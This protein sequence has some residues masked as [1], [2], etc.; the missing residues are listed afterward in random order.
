MYLG[1]YEHYPAVSEALD[2][3]R[4]FP[5]AKPLG[6]V[7]RRGRRD[8]FEPTWRTRQAAGVARDG[9]WQRDRF[10]RLQRTGFDRN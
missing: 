7:G 8:V 5:V 6:E 3:R 4:L 2:R 10:G 9:H 1:R